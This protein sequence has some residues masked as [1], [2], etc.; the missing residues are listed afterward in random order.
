MLLT[1]LEDFLKCIPTAE[2]SEWT[3]LEPFA[4][5]ADTTIKATLVGVDLYDY[6]KTLS[7]DNELK[8]TLCNLIAFQLYKNA[9]PFVDLIQTNNGFAVIS[10]S[11]QAPAS[12][13]RVERLILWC[14][15][16]IDLHTDLLIMQLMSNAAAWAEW[17]KFK[18]FKTLTNCFFL[19]G[20]DF[21]S[22]SK[23]STRADFLK[24]KPSILSAQKNDLS[25]RLS[26]DYV[27]ELIGQIRT[28]S[29]TEKNE[30]IVDS[31]KLVLAKY[32]EKEEHEAEELL[33]QIVVMMEKTLTDYPTYA[34][35]AEYALK[36]APKYENK[37]SDPTFFF[38]I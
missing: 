26:I 19:T 16:S 5:S 25:E 36:I 8:T 9:I 33:T 15:Q 35:S 17:V 22:Y 12:K 18:G 4:N 2:G 1:S 32:A 24:M 37:Q 27:A 10:N 14:E 38:G 21:A 7:A 23:Y 6:I 31:C 28:N 3:A 20:I 29:L 13:E 11:N 34:A 30:Q